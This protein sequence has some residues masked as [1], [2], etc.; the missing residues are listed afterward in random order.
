MGRADLHMNPCGPVPACQVLCVG[1]MH[2]ARRAG[3]E[4]MSKLI[5]QI[6]CNVARV[7]VCMHASAWDKPDLLRHFQCP[8]DLL[9]DG[10]CLSLPN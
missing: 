3:N 1:G 10:E 8:V 5:L 9:S 7:C 6:T 2:R 4:G